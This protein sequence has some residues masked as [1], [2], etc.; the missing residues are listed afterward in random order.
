MSDHLPQI[1]LTT[2]DSERLRRLADAASGKFPRTAE[3]LAREVDRAELSD[4]ATMVQ[5][6]VTMG[7]EV[8][9]RDD[10]T[11]KT[12][13]VILVY[14]DEADLDAGKISVLT[15]IG[16]ALIGLSVNQ[17]I[18]FETPTGAIRSVTVESVR[19]SA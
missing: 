9:Y 4:D 16:A 13:S 14:P 5:S 7:S 10:E 3:F 11:G 17:S 6:L 2:D 12:R 19:K 8:I 15:P 18:E 1:T